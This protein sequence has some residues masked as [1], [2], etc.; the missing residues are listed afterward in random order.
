MPAGAARCAPGG[1][2]SAEHER[3]ATDGKAW[4]AWGPYVSERLGHAWWRS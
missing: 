2:T 4:R 3:L 1:A